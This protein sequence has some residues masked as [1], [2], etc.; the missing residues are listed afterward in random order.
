MVG[1]SYGG[2]YTLFLSALDTRIKSAVSSSFFNTRD[3][4]PWSDWTWYNFAEKFDDAEVACLVYP[5]KLYIEIGEN[6][7][8]FDVK[9]GKKSYEK[10]L[11]LCKEVGTEWLEFITFE[12]THEFCKFDEPIEKLVADLSV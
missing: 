10:L 12:G 2:F 8:V 7:E 5:R 6:D 1:M 9:G 3:S 11:N 4:Y